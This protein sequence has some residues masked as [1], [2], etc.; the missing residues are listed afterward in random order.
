MESKLIRFQRL[1]VD[2]MLGMLEKISS[3]GIS[4]ESNYFSKHCKNSA[5]LQQHHL[6]LSERQA[7]QN[8][9]C[10]WPPYPL[11]LMNMVKTLSHM[12][13][14]LRFLK[15]LTK[16]RRILYSF[17]IASY[18]RVTLRSLS[19]RVRSSIKSSEKGFRTH[20]CHSS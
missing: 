1:D 3:S 5:K 16:S 19:S 15:R 2:F 17:D 13:K 20:R 12:K 7:F 11:Q 8:W 10:C 14:L 9:D 18:Q 4:R 6:H